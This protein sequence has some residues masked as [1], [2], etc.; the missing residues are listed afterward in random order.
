MIDTN[1]RRLLRTLLLPINLKLEETCVE[2]LRDDLLNTLG[3]NFEEHELWLLGQIDCWQEDNKPPPALKKLVCHLLEVGNYDY[4]TEISTTYFACHGDLI[5][6][7]LFSHSSASSYLSN[8]LLIARLADEDKMSSAQISV[9]MNAMNPSINFERRSL[10]PIIA[11]MKISAGSSFGKKEIDELWEMDKSS[12]EDAFGDLGLTGCIDKVTEIAS[13]LG[14]KKDLSYQLEVLANQNDTPEKYTPYIQILHYQCSILEYYDHLVKDFYEFSPRGQACTRLLDKYPNSIKN[15]S[16]PFLN[17]AKSVALVDSSW[18]ASKKN[19][20]YE[21]ALVLFHI[22]SELDKLG[23]AARKEL[24]QW[25]R[26]FIHRFLDLAEPL[27]NPLPNQLNEN[28]FNKALEALLQM[29]SG[30]KGIIEQRIVD[31][32]CLASYQK[33]WKSRGIGDAVNTSNLSKKK[34][35][36]CDFQKFDSKEVHAYEAHGGNL[37]QGYL[38][39]HM[40]TLPKLL[41]PRLNEWQSFSDV[42]D[43]KVTIWFIAHEFS[44]IVPD[45]V[46]ISGVDVEV[47]FLSFTKFAT[48]VGV[49][50]ALPFLK[51]HLIEPLSKST[52]PAFVRRAFMAIYNS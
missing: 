28:K 48:Q 23:Y 14:Y 45:K 39:E 8:L 2:A 43:W 17:N 4:K 24:A 34:L 1:Y 35:G 29:N 36:D 30:T 42:S 38:D 27:G 9:I 21:G 26:Y 25:L 50:H 18:A 20:E 19:K 37:S 44:A 47:K 3:G 41:K 40:R 49:E 33:D 12:I 22:L 11:K 32:L 13:S 46:N 15:A 52:T 5:K 6:T 51:S 7:H 10:Q 31:A 16:N